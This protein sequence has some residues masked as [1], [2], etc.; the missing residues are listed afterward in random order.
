MDLVNDL[1]TTKRCAQRERFT[2]KF[3]VPFF[4][5]CRPQITKLSMHAQERPQ[6][7]EAGHLH[8]A[9]KRTSGRPL[10]N[11]AKII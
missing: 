9:H 5:V 10:P 8:I 7:S 1:R 3:S 11:L 6:S 2:V 4:V